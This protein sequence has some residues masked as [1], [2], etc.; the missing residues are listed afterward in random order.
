MT[1]TKYIFY[2]ICIIFFKIFYFNKWIFNNNNCFRI[3]EI[4][5]FNSPVFLIDNFFLFYIINIIIAWSLNANNWFIPRWRNNI[6]NII[7]FE[8][9]YF[10]NIKHIFQIPYFDYIFFRNR[11]YNFFIYWWKRG[12]TKI[13]L[14]I[15]F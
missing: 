11:K 2:F 13:F 8:E 3:N 5:I 15:I 14:R 1:N 10:F 9:I 12:I 7:I 6:N 4:A